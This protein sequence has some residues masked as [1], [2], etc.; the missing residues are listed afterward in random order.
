MSG[1]DISSSIASGAIIELRK[2]AILSLSRTFGGWAENPGEF[3]YLTA[4]LAPSER[5]PRSVLRRIRSMNRAMP[6]AL[7]E[8]A[9][10]LQNQVFAS[11]RKM[12]FFERLLF[13]FRRARP[14]VPFEW[15]E[16]IIQT[17]LTAPTFVAKAQQIAYHGLRERIFFPPGGPPL[18]PISA[19][20]FL[21][22]I[23]RMGRP[24]GISPLAWERL[25]YLS[26]QVSNEQNSEGPMDIIVL[27]GERTDTRGL[28]ADARS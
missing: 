14:H 26:L 12:G 15:A 27:D 11:G 2:L 6:F 19:A 3:P 8:P 16:A 10:H 25:E 9:N 17:A 7:F 23:I 24:N 20:T 5:I 4:L 22:L 21:K 13:R 1:F 18:D 28:S